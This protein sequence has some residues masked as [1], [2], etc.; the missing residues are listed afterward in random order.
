VGLFHRPKTNPAGDAAVIDLRADEPA[1]AP[2]PSGP[3]WGMPT[4][5]PECGEHGYLDHINLRERV[6]EQH[7]PTCFA[8][9]KTAEEECV[10]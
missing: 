10:V 4:R 2:R 8:R 6:M 7:C 9:W 1:L 5:C 3:M